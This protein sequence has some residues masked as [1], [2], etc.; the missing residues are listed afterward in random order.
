MKKVFT[1]LLVIA[2]TSLITYLLVPR[3]YV[4]H[5]HANFAM[6][7]DGKQEDFSSDAYMEEVSRCGVTDDV[8]P[9]DR[10][11]LHDNK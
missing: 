9:Q 6:Y 1:F 11:H 2:L 10:I 5:Y 4:V 8:H 3:P 7:I